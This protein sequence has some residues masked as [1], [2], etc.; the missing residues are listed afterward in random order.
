MNFIGER[1]VQLGR[2]GAPSGHQVEPGRGRRAR[3]GTGDRIGTPLR[4]IEIDRLRGLTGTEDGQ[5]DQD[6]DEQGEERHDATPEVATQREWLLFEGSQV[7]QGL[8]S[9]STG[10]AFAP[11]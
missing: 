8:S 5:G 2:V 7:A 4:Q 1:L 6:S 10:V 11:D 3:Y 9:R